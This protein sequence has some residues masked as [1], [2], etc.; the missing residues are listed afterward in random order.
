MFIVGSIYEK[1]MVTNNT[2]QKQ[3]LG[4]ILVEN[5]SAEENIVSE[6]WNFQIA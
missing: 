1:W 3:Q 4:L 2:C 5:W 6:K